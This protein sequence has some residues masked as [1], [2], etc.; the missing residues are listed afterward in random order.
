MKKRSCRVSKWA[1]DLARGTWELAPSGLWEYVVFSGSTS[2][3]G[4]SLV[5]WLWEVI[6]AVGTDMK[7]RF[8]DTEARVPSEKGT[9]SRGCY[10][11]YKVHSLSGNNLEKLEL[12][13]CTCMEL[14]SANTEARVTSRVLP[15]RVAWLECWQTI[16]P[17]MQ[18]TKWWVLC[19]QSDHQFIAGIFPC[20]K[21]IYGNTGI[22]QTKKGLP[23][24]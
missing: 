18:L 8:G 1:G 10:C 13:V 12:P 6:I 21:L 17:R 5:S 22:L 24:G 19:W 3:G 14:S 20:N 15:I 11:S 2:K 4:L 9:L 7:I 16:P 23:H